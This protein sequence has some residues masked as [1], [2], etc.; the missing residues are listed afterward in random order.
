MGG[1]NRRNVLAVV[2]ILAGLAV[3]APYTGSFVLLLI[4]QALIFG[5][6]AMSVDLLPL[7]RRPTW[8]WAPI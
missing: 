8:E 4:T 3:I 5:I 1:S 6:L 2:G 7:G